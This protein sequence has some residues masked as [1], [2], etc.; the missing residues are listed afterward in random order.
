LKLNGTHEPV[1]YADDVNILGGSL[2]RVRLPPMDQF[3]ITDKQGNLL[4]IESK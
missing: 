2:H 1:V 4:F 3:S